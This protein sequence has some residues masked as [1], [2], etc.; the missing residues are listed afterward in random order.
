MDPAHK[1]LG[2]SVHFAFLDGLRGTA[3]IAVFL[4]HCLG[5]AFGYDKLPWNGWTRNFNADPSFLALYPLTYGWCGV[6]MFFVVSGF[7]IHLSYTRNSSGGWLDF[8][9]RRLFRVYPPYVFAILLFFFVWPWGK[10]SIDSFERLALLV[11]HLVTVHHLD[12]GFGNINSSFWS[13]AVEIHLYVLY[14][15]IVF[16]QR[17]IGFRKTLLFTLFIE[18]LIRSANAFTL[19]H[20]DSNLPTWLFYSPLSFWFSWTLGAYLADSHLRGHTTIFSSLRFDLTALAAICLPLFKPTMSFSFPAFAILT[21][22]AISRFIDNKWIFAAG[23]LFSAASVHISFVGRISYSFY[24]LHQPIIC[25]ANFAAIKLA[26]EW[27]SSSASRFA[28][29]CLTYPFTLLASYVLCQSV[30]LQSIRLGRFAYKKCR[31]LP[32]VNAAPLLILA[33]VNTLAITSCT[34]SREGHLRTLALPVASFNAV[35][36]KKAR[37]HHTPLV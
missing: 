31:F 34:T 28:G 2:K 11:S 25:A 9:F 16:S 24:L 10:P 1:T 7:C 29:C 5:E 20:L 26:P 23:P 14:V 18:L 4:F 6:P 22:L 15:L 21:A 33:F 35:V 19:L 32:S 3:I 37:N 17:A 13:V 27:F 30:E 36:N 12:P 8:F